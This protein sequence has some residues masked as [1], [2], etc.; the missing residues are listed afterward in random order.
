MRNY[1][2]KA[3][4]ASLLSLGSTAWL[5]TPCAPLSFRRPTLAISA[6][7]SDEMSASVSRRAALLGTAILASGATPA[8]ALSYEGLEELVAKYDL[9]A[10]ERNNNGAPEKHLPSLTVAEVSCAEEPSLAPKH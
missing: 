9:T 10:P 8:F 4:L 5:A 2:I 3:L 6:S 1:T 7:K